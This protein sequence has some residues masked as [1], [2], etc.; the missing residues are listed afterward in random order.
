[1]LHPDSWPLFG[2][3]WDGVDYVWTF[4]PFGWNENPFVYQSLLEARARFLRA[5]GISCLVFVDESWICGPLSS[6]GWDPRRQ[7]AAVAAAMP[8]APMVSHLAGYYLT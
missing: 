6:K 4:L 2:V 1:M 5:E 8:F 7:W 3:H